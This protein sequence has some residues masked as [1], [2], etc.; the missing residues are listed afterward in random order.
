LEE[1]GVDGRRVC[2]MR[3]QEMSPFPVIDCHVHVFPDGLAQAVRKWFSENAWE[4]HEEGSQEELLFRLFRMGLKGAILLPYA[5]KPGIS[6]TLNE[7]VA[8]LTRRFPRAVGFAAIHQGDRDIKGTLRKAFA[9]LGLKG[10]KIHCHVQRVAPDARELDPIYEE[11][12]NWDVPVLIHAGKEPYVPAYGYDVRQITGA[13]RV[14]NV[15]RRY[16]SLKLIVPHLGFDE[17]EEFCRLLDRFP[18]L[19][20]DTTMMLAK[21]FPVEVRRELLSSYAD[22]ILY[23]TDYPHIPY[24]V[25]RELLNLLEM[26]LREGELEL[27]LH[28]NATRLFPGSFTQCPKSSYERE[29]LEPPKR[30]A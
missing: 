6:D 4:F 23:G 26:G 20:L 19:Y 25:E 7:F 8:H 21:F 24:E 12:V 27:I 5:H 14:E 18:N 17:T 13:R 9:A 28:K 2:P 15:L 22:R 1:K 11:A 16:C 29:G 30:L 3:L 10:I